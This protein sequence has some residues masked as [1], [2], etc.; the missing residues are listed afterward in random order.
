VK[1]S[2][3]F[4]LYHGS[5]RSS[6]ADALA[7]HSASLV[8]GPSQ[9]SDPLLIPMPGRIYLTPSALTAY[10]YMK[11]GQKWPAIRGA[12]L[13][14]QVPRGADVLVDEDCVGQAIALGYVVTRQ[15][16]Y[17]PD[18]VRGACGF[19]SFYGAGWDPKVVAKDVSLLEA[20]IEAAEAVVPR[21]DLAPLKPAGDRPPR[22]TVRVMAKVGK[23]LSPVLGAALAWKLIES[24]ANLAARPPVKVLGG[25]V[26]NGLPPEPGSGEPYR[27]FTEATYVPNAAGRRTP[28]IPLIQPPSYTRRLK[29]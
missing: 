11:M 18:D 15:S 12:V 16:W 22:G 25:W 28:P 7:G 8:A 3:S 23:I 5:S 4:V 24:G 21:R 20:L 10:Q 19:G 17:G 26:W 14:V 13:E 29:R 27:A 1:L 6:W 2:R 9:G